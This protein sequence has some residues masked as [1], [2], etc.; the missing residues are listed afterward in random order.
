[1]AHVR[2]RG[3]GGAADHVVWDL[4][5]REGRLLV[6]RDQDFLGLSVVL[7]APPKVVW[8]NIGNASNSEVAA[9]LLTHA[10]VV[11]RFAADGDATVLVLSPHL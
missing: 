2:T 3:Y 1:V 4:A 8:A 11:E 9:L 5:R 10:D 6:T 7:G